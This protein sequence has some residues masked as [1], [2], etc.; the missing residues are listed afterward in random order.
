MLFNFVVSVKD[1]R[2][3]LHKVF[4]YKF[5]PDCGGHERGGRILLYFWYPL[6]GP[7]I[8]VFSGQGNALARAS[9]RLLAPMMPMAESPS[10][11][12]P[13]QLRPSK[14]S[15]GYHQVSPGQPRRYHQLSSGQPRPAQASSGGP[16][17]ACMGMGACW[18]R[19]GACVGAYL[20]PRGASVGRVGAYLGFFGAS[21]GQWGRRLGQSGPRMVPTEC[22]D[23]RNM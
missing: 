10:Q 19:V 7:R 3:R 6:L 21:I 14:A 5:L 1:D 12:S 2:G 11:A 17:G 18:R 23:H 4:T 20:E 13:G 22:P 15:S 16:V 9:S 8:H